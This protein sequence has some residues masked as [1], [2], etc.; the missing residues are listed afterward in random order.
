[1]EHFEHQGNYV[2]FR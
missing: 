1:M 2:M